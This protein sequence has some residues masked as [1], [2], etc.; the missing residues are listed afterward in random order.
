[1]V[2]SS[3]WADA[4]AG[5]E[6]SWSADLHFVNIPYG[7]C[8]EYTYDHGRDCGL[9]G[10]C[11]V[12]AIVNYT[13]RA[14]DYSLDVE[15]RGE[16]LKFLFHLV[17]DAHQPLHV[18]FRED[19]G[20]N[21]IDLTHPKMSLHEAWDSY[22]MVEYRGRLDESI[23][24]STGIATDLLEKH[25]LKAVQPISMEDIGGITQE[26][27]S[28]T[29]RA[30]TCDDAYKDETGEWIQSGFQLDPI[31]VDSRI[32]VMAS[33]F[34]E[35][36]SRLAQFLNLV[37]STYY[38]A[39]LFGPK[40][41][42][43][44]VSLNAAE[45]PTNRFITLFMEDEF[46]PYEHLLEPSEGLLEDTGEGDE[47][48]PPLTEASGKGKTKS[49]KKKKSQKET[50]TVAAEVVDPKDDSYVLI[51]HGN[52]FIVTTRSRARSAR[53]Q[54]STTVLF[55]IAFTEKAK[56]GRF[57]FDVAV[58]GA[59][60]LT[61]EQI[62][63]IFQQIRGIRVGPIDIPD[64][65]VGC[66]GNPYFKQLKSLF[67]R[68]KESIWNPQQHSVDISDKTEADVNGLI[69]K[70]P[71]LEALEGSGLMTSEDITTAMFDAHG[72]ELV[73]LNLSSSMRYFGRVD[74]ITRAFKETRFVAHVYNC[75]GHDS[76][77][78]Q[79][80][81]DAGLMDGWLSRG[82]TSKVASLLRSRR[83][84]IRG[85]K[86]EKQM[87]HLPQIQA[88]TFL[89]HLDPSKISMNSPTIPNI[90]ARFKS[91]ALIHRPEYP[92]LQTVEYILR[93][94]DEAARIISSFQP[95]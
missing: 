19:C 64:V 43:G 62:Q 37:A 7:E 74:W 91:F 28:R 57:A 60:Q 1:M 51:K 80:W 21:G 70:K 27:V 45:S 69:A 16:A 26:I 32:L 63:A 24:S 72:D 46:D 33:Q 83:N 36:G 17:G 78:Y 30:H 10:R 71:S 38:E 77:M 61:S 5:G 81:F 14:A 73:L 22:L 90:I 11:V 67:A 59:G 92:G 55:E 25:P 48:E 56:P 54:P 4:V 34:R 8:K 18:G 49:K 23:R 89:S 82:I 39:E 50:S 94:P 3:S 40:D 93:S 15:Q 41:A 44:T 75:V 47:E 29:A 85:H 58:F 76:I 68:G 9:D 2:D 88:L 84:S 20:G 52:T 79:V 87:H 65:M 6:Y 42:D 53:Y 35:A 12:S 13:M 86:I 31:Y 95:L 66:D